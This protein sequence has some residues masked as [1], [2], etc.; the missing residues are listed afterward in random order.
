MPSQIAFYG[1]QTRFV[2]QEADIPAEARQVVYY[3]L[4]IGHHVGVLDCFTCL[5]QVPV[6]EFQAWLAQQPSGT[7]RTK[8]EGVLRFGEIEINKSHIQPLATLLQEGSQTSP[9]WTRKLRACLQEMVLEP[10]YYLMV[11]KL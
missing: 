11:K 1:L 8:L 2:N 5:F 3:S 7:G 10:A 6:E 4:A 9:A